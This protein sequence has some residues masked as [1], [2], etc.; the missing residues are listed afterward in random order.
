MEFKEKHYIWYFFFKIF[1]SLHIK[2]L[3]LLLTTTSNK[4]GLIKFIKKHY[5]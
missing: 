2:I 3:L 1:I 5:V 4:L